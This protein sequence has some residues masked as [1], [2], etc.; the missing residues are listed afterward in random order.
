M[1]YRSKPPKTKVSLSNEGKANVNNDVSWSYDLVF[2]CFPCLPF[3]SFLSFMPFLWRF[4]L[5]SFSPSFL[6]VDLVWSFP[7]LS[8]A[9]CTC[10]SSFCF[11]PVISFRLQVV[12]F[13]I[14]FAFSSGGSLFRLLLRSGTKPKRREKRRQNS[15][16][17]DWHGHSQ[18]LASLLPHPATTATTATATAGPSYASAAG[19][20]L[21]TTSTAPPPPPS[22]R[23][24]LVAPL[25]PLLLQLSL[26]LPLLVLRMCWRL[27]CCRCC[28]CCYCCRCCPP[29][30]LPL[31]RLLLFLLLA[32]HF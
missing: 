10:L 1:E 19:F 23:W 15:R 2:A 7:I 25:L 22:L 11:S 30:L 14:L 26:P 21:T 16:Q 12:F 5:D 24:L 4:L 28:H 20:C 3:V 8:H 29:L 9:A 32:L 6:S 13:I 17:A 27:C 18:E 31:L